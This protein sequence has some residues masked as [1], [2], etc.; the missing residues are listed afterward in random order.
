MTLAEKIIKYRTE[1]GISQLA[2]AEMIGTSQ[3]QIHRLEKGKPY[4]ATTERR[5]LNLIEEK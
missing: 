1:K 4:L 2:M 5:I 3:N